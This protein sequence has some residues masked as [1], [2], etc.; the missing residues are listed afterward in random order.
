MDYR[1]KKG[2]EGEEKARELIGEILDKCPHNVQKFDNLIIP[3]MSVYASNGEFTTELDHVLVTDYY[4]F[5]IETKNENYK[6]MDYDDDLWMLQNGETTSNPIIQNH[7]HK[8]VF[9]EKFGL[10]ADKAITVELLLIQKNAK[11][12]TQFSNDYVF[13]K[14]NF[15]LFLL[16]LASSSR[17]IIDKKIISDLSLIHRKSENMRHRH[18]KNIEY[19][20]DVERWVK[21]HE[22]HYVFA[23]TDRIRCP[24]CKGDLVFR[25]STYKDSQR[26]NQRRS[27]QYFLGCSNYVNH[28]C[29][30]IV[31]Y[32]GVRGKGFDSLV[33]ISIEERVLEGQMEEQEINLLESYM[34]IKE[35]NQELVNKIS[36]YKNT[37]FE[38]DKTIKELEK[39]QVK[40]KEKNKRLDY[41]RQLFRHIIGPFYVKDSV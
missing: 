21:N 1:E 40:L 16:L 38:K 39:N 7:M 24:L 8:M 22:K 19:A 41:E 17:R 34:S 28:E 6:K 5:I 12:K 11:L 32:S 10:S 20:E 35:E 33:R 23:R 15:H 36:H 4:V 29:K 30:H 26:N 3:Y 14:E 37:L 25:K 9:C 13:T 27:K 18:K 31:N 2:L